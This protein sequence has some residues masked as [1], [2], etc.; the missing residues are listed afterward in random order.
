MNKP[1]EQAVAAYV[2]MIRNSWT[3]ARMTEAE[4][5]RLADLF[6]DL[7]QRDAIKGGFESRWNQLQT[8]YA[9]FLAGIGYNGFNWR[10]TEE[11]RTA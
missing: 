4:Q 7:I 9:A 6:R 2:K 3:Y 8:I 1:K 10:D 5:G 11:A